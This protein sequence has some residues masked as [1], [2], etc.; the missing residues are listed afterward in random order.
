M[1]LNISVVLGVF[2]SSLVQRVNEN[3]NVLVAGNIGLFWKQ[4]L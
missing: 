2:F 3:L 1:E 4:M